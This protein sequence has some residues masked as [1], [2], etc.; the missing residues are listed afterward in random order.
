M[1]EEKELIAIA[2]LYNIEFDKKVLNEW[3]SNFMIVGGDYILNNYCSNEYNKYIFEHEF[4]IQR[5]STNDDPM[6][7]M[8]EYALIY[9]V[10]LNYV[11]SDFDY[12]VNNLF[13]K[14]FKK[15]LYLQNCTFIYTNKNISFGLFCILYDLDDENLYKNYIYTYKYMNTDINFL[16]LDT[17][18]KVI[19]IEDNNLEDNNCK[20]SLVPEYNYYF[21]KFGETDL[22]NIFSNIRKYTK[23][24]NSSKLNV[25]LDFYIKSKKELN[26]Y[27]KIIDLSIL[28][29][30]TLCNDLSKNINITKTLTKIG[31]HICNYNKMNSSDDLFKIFYSLR[32]NI[33]HNGTL[34]GDKKDNTINKIKGFL[35]ID[36]KENISDNLLLFKFLYEFD[37]SIKEI[38]KFYIN[39]LAKKENK[40]KSIKDINL[41]HFKNDIVEN[42]S[43]KPLA[44]LRS[45]II[46]TSNLWKKCI[47]LIERLN[48]NRKMNT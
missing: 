29:E 28:L 39:E 9:R 10:K 12:T 41:E 21:S 15:F 31:N 44:L 43:S 5:G 30:S 2:S 14:I 47:Y 11:C 48:K 22:K 24:V 4:L 26:F 17:N 45:I 7:R 38:L 16:N 13:V 6:F 46:I 37:K 35:N 25:A 23:A 36:K 8:A 19:M 42:N 27:N 33:I 18:L 1:N 20:K 40:N 32:S 3:H 34:K